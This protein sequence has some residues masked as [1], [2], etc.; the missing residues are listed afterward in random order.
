MNEW[1]GSKIGLQNQI[2][3]NATESFAEDVIHS[4]LISCQTISVTTPTTIGSQEK[5]K[6]I[7]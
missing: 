5:N 7:D 2:P 4:T 6:Q 1:H 3:T